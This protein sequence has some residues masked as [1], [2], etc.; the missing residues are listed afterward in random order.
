MTGQAA[1]A[2]AYADGDREYR[3]LVRHTEACAECDKAEGQCQVASD[4]SRAWRE[5]RR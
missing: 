1:P 3:A 2:G 4:L 5:A